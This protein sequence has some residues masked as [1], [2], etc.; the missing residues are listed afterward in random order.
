[1]N[2]ED[3]TW[4]ARALELAHRAATEGE[5]PVGAVVVRDG[6]VLGEGWNRPI[7]LC[8]P[9]A[10]AEIQALRAAAQAAGNYRLPGVTLYSTLEPCTMCAGAMVHARVARLVFGTYDP[11]SGAAVSQ[12]DLLQSAALNHHVAWEVGLL[13][14]ECATLLQTF[15]RNR[16]RISE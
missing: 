8:D 16:R 6:I 2:A 12:F 13:R 5:V 10:H 11:R 3:E 9:T 4:M 14:E 7:G 1:M 15:F